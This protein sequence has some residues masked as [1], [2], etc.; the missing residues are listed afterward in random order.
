MAKAKFFMQKQSDSLQFIGPKREVYD[1][2]VKGLPDKQII[3]AVFDKRKRMK[4]S[5]Q[6]GY[7]YAVILPLSFRGFLDRGIDSLHKASFCG[8]EVEIKIDEDECDRYFK[9]MYQVKRKITKAPRKRDMTDEDMSGLIDMTLKFMAEYLDVVAPE[10]EERNQNAK[11]QQGNSHGKF[12]TRPRSDV[13]S[14]PNSGGGD[15]P[16]CQS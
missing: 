16:G 1:A 7:W 3:E 9:E 11:L 8:E 12:N 13:S 6:L 4:T 14:I 5:P 10:P 15:R 2:W